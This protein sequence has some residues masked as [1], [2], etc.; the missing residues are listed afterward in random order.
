M[1]QKS[2]N[3]MHHNYVTSFSGKIGH[4]VLQDIIVL[5]RLK[6]SRLINGVFLFFLLLFFSLA[7]NTFATVCS[8][9]AVAYSALKHNSLGFDIYTQ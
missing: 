8:R 6:D 3:T 2:Q 7:S 1:L 5:V 4:L 9:K